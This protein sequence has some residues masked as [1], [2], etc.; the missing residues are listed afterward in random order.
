MDDTRLVLHFYLM[1]NQ[2][3]VASLK[4][5]EPLLFLAKDRPPIKKRP[6]P[7]ALFLSAH[8]KNL[9]LKNLFVDLDV[10]RRVILVLVGGEKTC[11]V[12]F[13]LI[14]RSPNIV[15]RSQEK[16]VSFF[17]P[18]ELPPPSV[19][20]Y[21]KIS[22]DW[23][24]WCAKVHEA[25]F[26]HGA[27]N[28]KEDVSQ[29]KRGGRVRA[30]D[31]KRKAL[32]AL[33]E[34]LSGSE[35]NSLRQQGE[36]LKSEGA[37]DGELIQEY[38]HKAKALEKKISGT[39]ER[40]RILEDEILALEGMTDDEFEH[41]GQEK[42]A[43]KKSPAVSAGASFRKIELGADI[44]ASI[45]KSAAD[46]LA[47]LRKARAWDLWVH[48]K[49]EPSAH[50]IIFRRRNQDVSREQIEKVA[51][52]I[53]RQKNGKDLSFSSRVDVVVVECRYVRP[54]KGDRLGRVQYQNPAVY[55]FAS[56]PR[57]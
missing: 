5:G 51:F 36:A 45:G 43:Q 50:G 15:V 14:P 37:V 17:K 49:D 35:A 33:I 34:S 3:L 54:I 22:E 12:M 9:R 16:S 47:L 6:Q 46:N 52:G 56:K 21:E 31:K 41:T 8:G 28:A 18:K 20:T 53:L 39:K 23:D 42:A 26:S 44:V 19:I 38:F 32:A 48:L 7:V 11:E 29:L 2:Y 30:L 24:L 1:G 40:V 57:S 4:S 27:T 25:M 10:G 55:T 13:D